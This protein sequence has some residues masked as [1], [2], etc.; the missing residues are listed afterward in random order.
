M[1]LLGEADCLNRVQPELRPALQSCFAAIARQRAGARRQLA[2][3]L[4]D[5][6]TIALLDAWEQTLR[7]GLAEARSKETL[8]GLARRILRRQVRRALT[9][10]RRT[11]TGVPRPTARLRVLCKQLRYYLEFFGSLCP[12]RTPAPLLDA[13]KAAQAILGRQNDAAVQRRLLLKTAARARSGPLSGEDAGVALGALMQSLYEE[14]GPLAARLAPAC[15][16]L[17]SHLADFT[18][19]LDGL[20]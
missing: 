17:A 1:L 4:G 12:E 16:E 10:A 9:E 7:D 20:E 11:A 3:R 6:R 8:A 18:A 13:L 15:A 19:R 14:E 5:E 2:R